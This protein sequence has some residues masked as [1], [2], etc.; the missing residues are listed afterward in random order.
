MISF[1]KY[2]LKEG[3]VTGLAGSQLGMNNTS[4]IPRT[5]PYGFW[6]DKSGNWVDVPRL[7][8]LGAAQNIIKTA[9][10]YKEDKNIE[11]SST[12]S[13]LYWNGINKYGWPYRELENHGFMHVVITNALIFYKPGSAGI[14]PSQ[15]KFLSH[16]SDTYGRP[17][18]I[19][20][21]LI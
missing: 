5:A 17:A 6:V 2:F 8:H 20:A 13:S 4:D 12:D 21:E 14:T 15:R 7:G 11:I 16:I 9:Y 1:K 19:D 10:K 18:E 3:I